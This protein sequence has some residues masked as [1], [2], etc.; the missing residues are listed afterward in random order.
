[1][2]PESSRWLQ[3]ASQAIKSGEL[4]LRDDVDATA[5][6]AYY[7]MFYCARALL[8]NQG[9]KDFSKHSAVHAAYGEA[10]AKSKVLDPKF[11]KWL[12][13]SFDKRLKAD[14]DLDAILKTADAELM[15][16]QAREFLEA[17]RQ[18]LAKEKS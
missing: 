8:C 16:Q 10:F 11:H 3:K 9:Q 7:A 18:H 14:Y 5:G 15:L 2:M 17:A 13:V 4:T 12:I 1:M 6:R